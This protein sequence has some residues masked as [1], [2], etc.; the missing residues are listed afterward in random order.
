MYTGCGGL[1]GLV[2]VGVGRCSDLFGVVGVDD[3]FGC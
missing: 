3:L 1:G 2:L